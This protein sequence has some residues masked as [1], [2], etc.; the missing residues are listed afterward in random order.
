MAY[1]IPASP[2]F[3][4]VSPTFEERTHP[5]SLMPCGVHDMALLELIRTDVSR[6][7]IC[8]FLL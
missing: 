5:A 8:E 6:E 1:Y 4:P 7:M 3:E 2:V